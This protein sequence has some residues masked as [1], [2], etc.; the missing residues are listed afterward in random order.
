MENN[1]PQNTV[2][3][4]PS[5]P[6]QIKPNAPNAVASLVLGILSLAIGCLGVGL[7]LGIIGLVLASKGTKEYNAN[8]ERYKGEGMLKAGKIMS[9]IGIVLSGIAFIA[10]L[11]SG[12]GLFAMFEFLDM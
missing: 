6:N 9:I 7:I 5:T 4:N 12:A 2:I 11:I 10:M 3:T 1:N 8:P